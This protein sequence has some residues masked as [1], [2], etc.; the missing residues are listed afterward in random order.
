MK[1]ERVQLFG[2]EVNFGNPIEDKKEEPKEVSQEEVSQKEA[3]DTE[4]KKED[5]KPVNPE[6]QS[7]K[8]SKEPLSRSM[9]SAAK[10]AAD[11][12]SRGII[13]ESTE[14]KNDLTPEELSDLIKDNIYVEVKKTAEADVVSQLKELGYDQDTLKKARLLSMGATDEDVLAIGQRRQAAEFKPSNTEELEYF[15]LNYLK[16][17]GMDDDRASRLVKAATVSELEKDYEEG[18]KY[19]ND[20]ADKIELQVKERNNRRIAEEKEAEESLNK[21]FREV[22]DSGKLGKMILSEEQKGNLK[23]Q[24]FDK[25]EGG[26][27]EYEKALE[28]IDNNHEAQLWVAHAILNKSWDK[29]SIKPSEQRSSILKD[30]GAELEEVRKTGEDPDGSNRV[31]LFG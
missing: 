11:Y 21:S 8:E 5:E 15:V 18:I 30:L 22:I 17:K 23:K 3:I 7:S 16:Y 31:L 27:T 2:S 29:E 13:S 10:L 26:K 24:L 4:V 1:E 20:E 25:I 9:T 6:G 14:I 12:K 28:D 19:F